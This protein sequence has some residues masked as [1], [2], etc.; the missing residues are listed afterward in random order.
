MLADALLR[1]VAGTSAQLRLTGVTTTSSQS[2]VGIIATTFTQITISPVVMRKLRPTV[3]QDDSPRWE[4]L[5]S[6]TSV[7]AQIDTFD[8]PSAQALFAMT[9]VVTVAGKDYVIDA[10]ASNEAFGQTYIYRLSLREAYPQ[11]L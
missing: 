5:L 4:L 9:L 1:T 11:S 3:R 2:E 8:I 10:V 7:Q 6:A